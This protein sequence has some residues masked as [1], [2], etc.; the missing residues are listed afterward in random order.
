MMEIQW[1]KNTPEMVDTENG[2][3][4]PGSRQE[5]YNIGWKYVEA[6]RRHFEKMG[7][8]EIRRWK[9]VEALVQQ[10]EDT[11]LIEDMATQLKKQGIEN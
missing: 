2:I 1:K 5:A 8:Q 9:E 10:Y 6:T 3:V 4:K 7:E 11:K